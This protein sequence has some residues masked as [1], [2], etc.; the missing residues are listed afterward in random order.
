[1][2]DKE[3]AKA[4]DFAVGEDLDAISVDELKARI[5]V[6]EA[7]ITRLKQAIDAKQDQRQAADALFS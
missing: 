7:E 3:L 4:K 5:N 1:M 6:L 2:E